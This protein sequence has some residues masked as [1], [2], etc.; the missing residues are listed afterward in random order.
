MGEGATNIMLEW[1]LL[2]V[3]V[4]VWCWGE[5]ACLFLASDLSNPY[6]WIL[7][8]TSYKANPSYWAGLS[9]P[10]LRRWW[11]AANANFN[12][13]YPDDFAKIFSS[14]RS[15]HTLDRSYTSYLCV[16]GGET[17]ACWRLGSSRAPTH[18]SSV[19]LVLPDKG[20]SIDDSAHSYVSYTPS[21]Q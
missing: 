17:T 9:R 3:L 16:Q 7:Y 14:F 20:P 12:L 8:I 6:Y 2:L 5:L 19:L 15:E 21:S 1:I 18:I 11:L 10:R 4:S 13:T